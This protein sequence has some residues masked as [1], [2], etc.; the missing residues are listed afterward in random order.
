MDDELERTYSENTATIE[1]SCQLQKDDDHT[2]WL[3][4]EVVW[5]ESGMGRT[6]KVIALC[7]KSIESLRRGGDDVFYLIP[8]IIK[9][10]GEAD[11]LRVV[12]APLEACFDGSLLLRSA[13]S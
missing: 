12:F 1:R 11:A 4:E 9:E 2:G 6:G 5:V 3:K 8:V 7:V 10:S 13:R